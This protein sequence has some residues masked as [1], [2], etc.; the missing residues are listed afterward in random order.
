[1]STAVLP[2]EAAP[3]SPPAAAVSDPP[4]VVSAA[5]PSVSG[6]LSAVSIA[7]AEGGPEVS[8]RVKIALGIASAVGGTLI[9]AI[10]FYLSFGN[11]SHAGSAM[12]GF[13]AQDAPFF[14]VGVDAAITTC[15]VLDLFMACIRTSWPVLRVIAHVMTL[16]S[17]YFNAAAHGAVTRHWNMAL[18]HGLMPCLFVIGVEAGRRILVHQAALPGD[19]DVIPGHRWLLAYRPTWRIFRTMKLW[20]VGYA[21]AMARQRERAIFNAWNEYKAEL[22]VSGVAEGSEEALARLPKKLE[23]FG[24][25]VDEALALPDQMAREELRR[26]QEAERR[27]RALELDKERAER[28]E[29]KERLAHRREMAGLTADLAATEGVAEAQARGAVAE[30]QARAQAAVSAARRTAQIEAEAEENAAVAAANARAAEDGKRAAEA[31][32]QAEAARKQAAEDRR[33]TAEAQAAEAAA[34]AQAEAANAAAAESK[35]VAAQ[36]EQEAAEAASAA[37]GAAQNGA[38]EAEAIA[39]AAAAKARAAED[40]KRAAETAAVAAETERRAAEARARAAE[41]AAA[42]TEAAAR[43]EAA[44]AA[45]ARSKRD[46]AEAAAGELETRAR[47]AEIELRAVEM[48]DAA[49]LSP[50]DRTIRRVARMVLARAGGDADGLPLEAITGEFGVSVGTASSYRQAAADLLAG[51]YRPEGV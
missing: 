47:V 9:G 30:A 23:P 17:V 43:E 37:A 45:A 1:M 44:K 8:R 25:T 42:E 26:R 48:E 35:R 12:F 15:L 38:T 34:Q 20:D 24:L 21:E 31:E 27:G 28:E 3:A 51:G 6:S 33:R 11:L 13:S 32:A 4:P 18:A 10:G 41:A 36:A 2:L 39:R 16:A 5:R 49:R 7:R 46:A 29:E 22:A 19:H 50:K 14:A 40:R